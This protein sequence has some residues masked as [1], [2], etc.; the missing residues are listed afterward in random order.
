MAKRR[1]YAKTVRGLSMQAT[2]IG[3]QWYTRPAYGFPNVAAARRRFP[4][5]GNKY[6][7]EGQGLVMV[8]RPITPDPFKP[9]SKRLAGR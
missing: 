8:Y 3:G 6:I 4:G 1:W 2:L 5:K 9:L 7:K